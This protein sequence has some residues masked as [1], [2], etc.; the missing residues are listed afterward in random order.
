MRDS[1]LDLSNNIN[2]SLSHTT[3]NNIIKSK[4]GVSTKRPKRTN[5]AKHSLQDVLR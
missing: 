2:M 1:N 4:K 5:T 3:D